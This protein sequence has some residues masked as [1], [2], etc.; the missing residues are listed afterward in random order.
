[1]SPGIGVHPVLRDRSGLTVTS[2]Y[3]DPNHLAVQTKDFVVTDTQIRGTTAWAALASESDVLECVHVFGNATGSPMADANRNPSREA[4][5]FQVR[6]IG[7]A[8]AI[9]GKDRAK[10]EIVGVEADLFTS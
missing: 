2:D 9:A 10:V 7:G 4:E 3:L 6:V 5:V 1:M 8:H